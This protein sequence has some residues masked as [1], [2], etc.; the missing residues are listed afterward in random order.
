MS[1]RII[2]CTSPTELFRHY[3][4]QSEAQPAYIELDLP[5]GVLLAD[6]NAEIGNGVPFTVYHGQDRRYTIP[7]LTGDAANRVMK[8]I[9]PLADRILADWEEVWDGNNTVV[10]LGED[11]QAAE[12][13]IETKLGLAHPYDQVFEENDLIGQWDVDAALNGLEAEEYGITA[14]TSDERLDEIAAEIL[15]DLADCGGNTVVVCA[16]LEAHLRTLRDDAATD[17]DDED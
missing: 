15:G 10:R 14:D 3:D 8:E 16:G 9:A 2:D 1:I 12:D 4:G 11:A 7:V 5:N 17:Q 6:Y 13:E